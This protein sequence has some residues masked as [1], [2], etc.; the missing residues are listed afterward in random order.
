[1]L[2]LWIYIIFPGLCI[3][4]L[5]LGFFIYF[6]VGILGTLVLQKKQKKIIEGVKQNNKYIVFLMLVLSYL[7]NLISRP[8]L[9][10]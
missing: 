4:L 10:F 5:K 1:M 9:K 7:N 6:S 2:I 8:P 3:T